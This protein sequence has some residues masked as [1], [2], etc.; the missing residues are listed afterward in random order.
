VDS[1]PLEMRL[2]RGEVVCWLAC[3]FALPARDDREFLFG[4][5]L[6]GRRH[7]NIS[8]NPATGKTTGFRWHSEEQAARLGRVLANFAETAAGWLA[9]ALP[10]YAALWIRDRASFR[11]EEEATRRLRLHA[12]NDLLH[13]DAFPSR[14][15][16]GAR[17][18]RLFVNINSSEPR[19]W[20]TSETFPRLLERYRHRLGPPP[21]HTTW[22]RRLLRL[23][24]GRP[25]RCAYDDFMLRLHHHMKNDEQFQEK[26]PRRFW[27]FTAGSA[28]LAFT[29]AVSHAELRG[30][31]ALEQSFFVPVPCLL[32][33]SQAPYALFQRAYG[34]P[35]QRFAA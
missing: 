14:P 34:L 21:A 23:L 32:E 11:P 26:G 5:T 29:D 24:D 16:G 7:K 22:A 6:G 8:Y 19:V 33:P 25:P 18:L 20:M 30:C 15:S 3:P 28:W 35:Q 4:Q 13:I 17:I 31:Y 2:E 1:T 12:R 10:R 27:S 9:G